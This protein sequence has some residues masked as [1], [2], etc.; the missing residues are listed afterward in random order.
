MTLRILFQIDL[1]K[2]SFLQA[3]K[4]ALRTSQLD[5][6]N[7]RFA[8][9]LA[10]GVLKNEAA[11]DAKIAPLSTEWAIDRQPVVDRNILRMAAFELLYATQSPVLTVVNEA[12]EMAK[13]Y[14][15]AESGRF[16]NG[17]LA[18]LLRQERGED[19]VKS[20]EILPLP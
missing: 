4:G 18:A 12:V 17:V 7:R 14:S 8:M 3:V 5:R 1:G 6:N 10:R 16:V 9:E 13:K 11:I 19:L 2:Q 15:T 20:A